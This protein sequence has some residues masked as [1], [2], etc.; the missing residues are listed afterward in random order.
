MYLGKIG[1]AFIRSRDVALPLFIRFSVNAVPDNTPVMDI[2]FSSK[3]ERYRYDHERKECVIPSRHREKADAI[4]EMVKNCFVP[5][6]L[7]HDAGFL[8]HSSF[9]VGPGRSLLLTGVSGIGKSTLSG[10]LSPFFRCGNDDLNLIQVKDTGLAAHSTP[11]CNWQK[12][13]ENELP[14][15]LSAP[16]SQIMLLE[17]EQT[18]DSSI[19]P[20]HDKDAV[21]R[22]L[23]DNQQV[24]FPKWTKR[25]AKVLHRYLLE[26]VDRGEFFLLRHNLKDP[27][28]K[29]HELICSAQ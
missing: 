8:F 28:G 14:F 23:I 29:V 24:F 13:K 19:R 4:N 3:S 16:V 25:T 15:P 21:W 17:K 2:S 12:V 1:P 5:F 11:F 22:Y 20:L 7:D 27:A 9:L 6:L 26:F 10:K 18:R